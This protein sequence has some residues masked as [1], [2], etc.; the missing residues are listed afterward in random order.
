MVDLRHLQEQLRAL[1]IE[2]HGWIAQHADGKPPAHASV[3]ELV[4]LK[5]VVDRIRPLLWIQLRRLGVP[6]MDEPGANAPP[7]P[8]YV[9][10][11]MATAGL[12]PVEISRRFAERKK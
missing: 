3:S 7:P 11:L 1:E 2:I 10:D 8:S 5:A 4:A 9:A 6:V 12:D